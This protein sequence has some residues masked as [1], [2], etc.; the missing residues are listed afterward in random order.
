MVQRIF[1]FVTNREKM[2][3]IMDW[4]AYGSLVADICITIITL[5][6]L[7][8]PN[9]LAQYLGS[10]NIILSVVVILSMASAF[11]IVGSKIY[12]EFLFRTFGLRYRMKNHISRIRG[13]L[14]RNGY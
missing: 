14:Y 10:V 1:S 6:S 2:K 4:L 7:F 9:N 3:K 5:S 13:K 11:L 12:E 8:Y